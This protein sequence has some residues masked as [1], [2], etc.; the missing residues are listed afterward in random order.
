MRSASEGTDTVEHDHLSMTPIPRGGSPDISEMQYAVGDLVRIV[1][2]AYHQ[3]GWHCATMLNIFCQ[4]YTLNPVSFTAITEGSEHT[5][6][7]YR[8]EVRPNTRCRIA[9]HTGLKVRS[10][11][12]MEHLA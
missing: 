11:P 3:S 7:A 10:Y 6:D 2:V 4:V 8:T 5:K 12:R 9:N 1:S